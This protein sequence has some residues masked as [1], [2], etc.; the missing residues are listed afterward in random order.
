ML[1]R[2]IFIVLTGVALCVWLTLPAPAFA[3]HQGYWGNNAYGYQHGTWAY[4]PG[5]G[6]STVIP[7]N[8]Y[9]WNPSYRNWN[10]PS[11]LPGTTPG[12]G[13]GTYLYGQGPPR[14]TMEPST[15]YGPGSATQFYGYNRAAD[16]YVG[17]LPTAGYSLGGYPFAGYSAAYPPAVLAAAKT[18]RAYITMRLPTADAE[19]FFDETLMKQSGTSRV[20]MTP[21]LDRDHKYSFQI[22]VRWTDNGQ[23]RKEV[24]TV[25]VVPGDAVQVDFT[26][27]EGTLPPPK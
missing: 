6:Y 17:T 26:K 18:A 10:N 16:T 25:P 13:Y 27:L 14:S 4:Y 24:R 9:M 23:E 7:G 19:V 11:P 2:C 1:R 3:Q 21:Q 5:Y 12:V 8:G 22:S 20:Y 15:Y